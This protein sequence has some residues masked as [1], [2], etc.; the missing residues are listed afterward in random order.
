MV[1]GEGRPIVHIV[2]QRVSVLNRNIFVFIIQ[3]LE[4][5]TIKGDKYTDL[6]CT[7]INMKFSSSL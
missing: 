7:L 5:I 1:N 3:F 4:M 6:K 2:D